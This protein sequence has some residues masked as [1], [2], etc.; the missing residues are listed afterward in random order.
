M[1]S[2]CWSASIR[3]RSPGPTWTLAN[4]ATRRSIVPGSAASIMEPNVKAQPVEPETLLPRTSVI[5]PS[6]HVRPWNV[7]IL[8]DGVMPSLPSDPARM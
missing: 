1:G 8:K 7:L 3:P 4:R 2:C 5:E 6:P